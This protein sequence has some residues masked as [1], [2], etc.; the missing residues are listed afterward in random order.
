MNQHQFRRSTRVLFSYFSYINLNK[1]LDSIKSQIKIEFSIF[2]FRMKI[3]VIL[4]VSI[5]I[6]YTPRFSVT[7]CRTIDACFDETMQAITIKLL[8]GKMHFTVAT[9]RP[10]LQHYR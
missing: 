3:D 6:D 10:F 4:V 1:K 9:Q 7:T 8:P 2:S 5:I